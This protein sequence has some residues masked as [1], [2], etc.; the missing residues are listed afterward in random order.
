MA[1]PG[2]YPD[3]LRER[4]IRLAVDARRCPATRSGALRRIGDQLDINP[5]TLRNGATQ[6]EIDA[7]AAP[8]CVA[9]RGRLNR[10]IKRRTDV[11]GVFPD[12]RHLSAGSMAVLAT[13]S[14]S[15]EEVT[16]PALIA[17]WSLHR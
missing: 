12:R 7:C 10:D 11:V 2:K 15:T 1:T 5:E 14:D 17:S 4:A 6:A 8:A 13:R 9:S 16:Q 3:E